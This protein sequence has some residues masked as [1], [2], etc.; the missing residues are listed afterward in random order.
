METSTVQVNFDDRYLSLQG[1]HSNLKF[2]I[3]KISKTPRTITL[4]VYSDIQ[5]V[6]RTDS[7]ALRLK[8]VN[9]KLKANSNTKLKELFAAYNFNVFDIKKLEKEIKN[10]IKR[11]KYISFK[12][13]LQN[14]VERYNISGKQL[15]ELLVLIN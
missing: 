7:Y 6:H 14:Y 3:D 10:Y 12:E 9:N 15:Q 11:K 4:A 1:K 5:R 8:I 13:K 2:V